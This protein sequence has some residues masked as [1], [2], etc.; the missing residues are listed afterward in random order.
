MKRPWLY[1]LYLLYCGEAGVFLLLAPWSL[2][3]I[4]SYYAQMPLLREVLLSGYV[5]G[6][7]SAIGLLHLAAGMVDFLAFRRELRAS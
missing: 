1:I 3:W 2:L 6:G 7:V 5:R 4:H